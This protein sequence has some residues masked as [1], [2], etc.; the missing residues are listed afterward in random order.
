M[1]RT[2]LDGVCKTDSAATLES[3]QQQPVDSSKSELPPVTMAT[4][5]AVIET[6][7]LDADCCHLEALIMCLEEDFGPYQSRADDLLQKGKAEFFL[8]W[9]IFPQ[10]SDVVFEDP[11]SGVLC[12]GRVSTSVRRLIK[13]Y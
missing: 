13:R 11:P 12:A 1:L 3:Q 5:G 6:H 8:L 9:C 4:I 10:G 2:Q 7:S